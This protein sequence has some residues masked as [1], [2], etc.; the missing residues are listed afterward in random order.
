[1]GNRDGR[2]LH[3]LEL[4]YV[5]ISNEEGTFKKG[6]ESILDEIFRS[7]PFRQIFSKAG[8]MVLPPI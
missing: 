1:M 7:E 2:V 8:G 5:T 6:M 3:P 4:V